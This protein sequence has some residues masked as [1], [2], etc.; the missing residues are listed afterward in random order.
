MLSSPAVA[1]SRPR[2]SQPRFGAFPNEFCLKLGQRR[3]D[4]KHQPAIGS[5]GINLRPSSCQ[6][7]QA[8]LLLIERVDKPH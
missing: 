5:R 3:K 6:D 8:D 7:F 1:S 4:P 2:G